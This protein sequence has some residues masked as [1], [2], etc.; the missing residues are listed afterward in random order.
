M[1][2]PTFTQQLKCAV[3]SQSQS[4][5]PDTVASRPSRHAHGPRSL[6][7]RGDPANVTEDKSGFPA[8]EVSQSAR[9]RSGRFPRPRPQR[10]PRPRRSAKAADSD[11]FLAKVGVAKL[12]PIKAP[13]SQ[14]LGL[15]RCFLCC[16]LS[17][18]SFLALPGPEAAAR[19]PGKH[20]DEG[21]VCAEG[22]RS[23][24]RHHSLRAEGKARGTGRRPR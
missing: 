11:W 8:R 12:R 21:R 16:L 22:R 10:A 1:R 9:S 15:R 24:A 19:L 7:F 17:L 18:S 6:G 3:R 14:P 5:F 13:R 2:I 23:G 20:G 4:A